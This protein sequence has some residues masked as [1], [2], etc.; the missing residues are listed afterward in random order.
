MTTLQEHCLLALVASIRPFPLQKKARTAHTQWLQSW[1]R[2]A[3]VRIWT[4]EDERSAT[5][6]QLQRCIAMLENE[7]FAP[8]AGNRMRVQMRRTNTGQFEIMLHDA[9]SISKR[10]YA[11]EIVLPSID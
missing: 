5:V 3:R 10:V 9:L 4:D 6:I 11:V 8:P 2:A 7:S 1:L